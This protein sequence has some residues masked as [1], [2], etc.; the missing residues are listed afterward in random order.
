MAKKWKKLA[1]DVIKATERSESMCNAGILST[2]EH[3]MQSQFGPFVTLPGAYS[4]SFKADFYISFKHLL[5]DLNSC[6]P[7]QFYI[8]W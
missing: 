7:R 4:G 2:F 6:T 3:E 8:S 1:S 5:R